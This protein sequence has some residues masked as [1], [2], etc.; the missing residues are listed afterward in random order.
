[1]IRRNNP[2]RHLQDVPGTRDPDVML[3]SVWRWTMR[4]ISFL[5][6]VGAGA[7][8]AMLCAPRAGEE[9]RNMLSDKAKQ[10][11]RYVTDQTQNVRD[12][13]AGVTAFGKDALE[14]QKSAIAKAAESAKETYLRETLTS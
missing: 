2:T 13:A 9:T 1:M 12:M 8:I 6:G 14:N 11:R 10:G 4:V 7:G 3:G 5:I